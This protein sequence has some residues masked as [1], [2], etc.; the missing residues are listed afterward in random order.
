M[1]SSLVNN[2]AGL[3]VDKCLQFPISSALV[4]SLGFYL[5]WP[6]YADPNHNNRIE[7]KRWIISCLITFILVGLALT[8]FIPTLQLTPNRI[9]FRPTPSC[10]TYNNPPR[11]LAFILDVNNNQA[12]Y[13]TTVKGVNNTD[14]RMKDA[15]PFYVISSWIR[16]PNH[17]RTTK[18]IL[19]EPAKGK[20]YNLPYGFVCVPLVQL[21]QILSLWRFIAWMEQKQSFKTQDT[22]AR[23][24][25]KSTILDGTWC[26]IAG[27]MYLGGSWTARQGTWVQHMF[28]SQSTWEFFF[29][30]ILSRWR[31]PLQ[32]NCHRKW[33]PVP[34]PLQGIHSR[35]KNI[36]RR[37][38]LMM[39]M[40]PW[41]LTL[42]KILLAV[43]RSSRNYLWYIYTL[44]LMLYTV[45]MCL[46]RIW[47]VDL[48][49]IYNVV[50]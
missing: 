38:L 50:Q 35:P 40:L 39:A 2:V 13:V 18:R 33:I 6:V 17:Y 34:P 46:I 22:S 48:W 11:Y 41:V 12:F 42:V 9:I 27:L 10:S 32:V 16:S 45:T 26:L 19:F 4:F 24:F 31:S 44:H 29:W 47:C 23:S 8:S 49:L 37:L 36:L 5:F 3:L 28:A 14:P 43:N 1:D 15:A 21:Q 20:P 7:G 25:W 30:K